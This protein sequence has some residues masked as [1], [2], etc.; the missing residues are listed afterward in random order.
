[1]PYVKSSGTYNDFLKGREVESAVHRED[2]STGWVVGYV[3]TKDIKVSDTQITPTEYDSIVADIRS[4]NL[5][6]PVPPA[7]PTPAEI[8]KAIADAAAEVTA[9]IDKAFAAR[10]LPLTDIEKAAITERQINLIAK[11]Q[12][13]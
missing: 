7:P 13:R 9:E 2:N 3:A 5:S 12:G 4:Y 6:L 11:A 8:A 10:G 1:M